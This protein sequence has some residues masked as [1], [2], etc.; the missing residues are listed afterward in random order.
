MSEKVEWEIVEETTAKTGGKRR[1]APSAQAMLGSWW[2]W[3][4]AGVVALGAVLL[5]LLVAVAGVIAVTVAAVGLVSFCIARIAMWL[6]P[7]PGGAMA[8]RGFGP[9]FK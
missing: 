9:P 4:V 2:R 1:A 5:M 3:K 6:R 8:R 7:G